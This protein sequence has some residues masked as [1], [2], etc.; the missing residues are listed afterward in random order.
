MGASGSLESL[1]SYDGGQGSPSPWRRDTGGRGPSIA[2][3]ILPSTRSRAPSARSAT[4]AAK[5]R[6]PIT[7]AID[8]GAPVEPRVVRHHNV[9]VPH[10]ASAATAMGPSTLETDVV[11]VAAAAGSVPQ[12]PQSPESYSLASPVHSF[13]GTLTDTSLEQPAQ[14]QQQGK[15]KG[16]GERRLSASYVSVPPPVSVTPTHA[17]DSVIESAGSG[18]SPIAMRGTG[19]RSSKLGGAAIIGSGIG[20]GTPASLRPTNDTLLRAGQRWRRQH[21]PTISSAA[22]RAR[23]PRV[24][25]GFF[26]QEDAS[27]QST[28]WLTSTVLRRLDGGSKHGGSAGGGDGIVLEGDDDTT[29]APTEVA[30]PEGATEVPDKAQLRGGA[31][32]DFSLKHAHAPKHQSGLFRSGTYC[33]REFAGAPSNITTHTFTRQE[34]AEASHHTC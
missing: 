23:L 31:A 16:K 24:L 32:M 34:A 29:T 19:R 15:G 6:P 18:L 7:L 14:Q 5:A 13:A 8:V 25:D 33:S 26:S 17:G 22:A 30:A 21:A 9:S 3:A 2:S 12:A 11:A 10:S 28:A 27:K 1:H 4:L 20:V